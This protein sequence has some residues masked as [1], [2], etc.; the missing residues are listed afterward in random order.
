MF[1]HCQLAG[2]MIMQSK[3]RPQGFLYW[4][5]G[6]QLYKKLFTDPPGQV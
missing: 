1:V 6:E 2:H 3:S 4:E 5:G